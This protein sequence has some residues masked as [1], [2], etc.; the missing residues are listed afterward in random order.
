MSDVQV[1]LVVLIALFAVLL[2]VLRYFSGPVPNGAHGHDG[3]HG[4]Q[5]S[6]K[7]F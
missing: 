2:G 7:R 4:H 5:P 1:T 3:E 6:T